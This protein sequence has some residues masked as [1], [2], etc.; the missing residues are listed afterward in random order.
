MY[1]LFIF[2]IMLDTMWFLSLQM[3]RPIVYNRLRMEKTF[4]WPYRFLLKTECSY[5]T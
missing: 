2:I 1:L 5:E 4:N 3:G